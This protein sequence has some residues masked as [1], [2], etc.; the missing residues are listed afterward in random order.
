MNVVM[1]ALITTAM[2]QSFTYN[3]KG[4][5]FKVKVKK[6]EAIITQFDYK[7]SVVV[8]PAEVAS[9]KG[10]TYT[11]TSVDLFQDNTYVYNTNSVAI[12][13][14]IVTI[15]DYCFYNFRNLEQIYIPV[16]IE[17]IGRKAFNSKRMPSKFVMPPSI[18]EFALSQ[19]E[20]VFPQ[21]KKSDAL[22]NI[23]LSDYTD[24]SDARKEKRSNFIANDINKALPGTSDVDSNIPTTSDKRESTYCLII[25]N[26]NYMFT[27]DVDYANTDGE[28]FAEYCKTTLGIPGKQV[29]VAPNADFKE[30][31]DQFG[32]LKIMADA[33]TSAGKEINFIVYYAGHGAPG[34]D[35]TCYL[36]PVD[37]K[38]NNV[39]DDGYSLKDIY[40]SLADLGQ[41]NTLMIVDA[42]Y[43]GTDRND[44]SIGDGSERGIKRV[45]N[46]K[47][48]GN[49]VVMS[50]ASNSETSM[51]YNEK[52]HGLFTYFL[53][54]KLKDS[55]GNVTYGDLHDYVRGAVMMESA[56]SGKTQTP[57]V[58]CSDKLSGSWKKMKF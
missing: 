40:K 27:S 2:A 5:D 43:S 29:H 42:C 47:V 49:V 22:G 12:E 58:I 14:G 9:P 45:K 26:E 17:R 6:N 51:A 35:G 52:A 30:M 28:V 19:G 41:T 21:I 39:K 32:W 20:E 55:K 10:H 36:L 46:E 56:N 48:G 15:C 3:Y 31:K 44:V 34:S 16:S 38:P 24:A 13:K 54:K 23:D 18:S 7:A 1:V 57:S 25:A 8:I 53:L 4:V 37:G 11:V 33:A 50:A